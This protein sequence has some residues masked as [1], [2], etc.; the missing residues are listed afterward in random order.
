MDT[1]LLKFFIAVYE[2]KNLTRAASQCFVS[3]PNISNGIK[4][5]EEELGKTLFE[6][7]KKGVEL[8]TEAH[9]LYPIAKRLV[10]EIDNLSHSFKVRKFENKVQIGIAESLPQEHKQ[11]FFRTSS[12]ICDSVEWIVNEIDRKNELNL[13]VREWK[14]EEDLFLPLWKEDYVLCIP[15]DNPLINKDLISLKDLEKETFIH[16]PPCEAHKQCLSILNH[17][18]NKMVTVANCS[19]KTETLT[20]LMAGLGVTF[21]P[22][23]FVDGWYGFEVKKYKGPRYFR[24]VGLAYPRKSLRN[25]AIAKIIEH[26]SKNPLKTTRFSEFGHYFKT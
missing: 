17:E 20:M 11:Q 13:L 15:N 6:R 22:E 9:Y 2:Q 23:S 24:E 3:Q 10:S 25:P 16:C 4:Q 26:F 14:Q 21:L 8:K 5:L 12:N 18:T 7:H 19:T 1:R